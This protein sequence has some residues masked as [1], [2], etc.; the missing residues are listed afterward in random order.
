M[1]V[2]ALTQI[3]EVSVGGLPQAPVVA[4]AGSA[5]TPI[6][7]GPHH[8]RFGIRSWHHARHHGIARSAAANHPIT[9]QW[10]V[11]AHACRQAF[12]PQ[13]CC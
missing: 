1:Q 13:S 3:D 9:H 11:R 10:P 8:A 2:L 5:L 6:P 4:D 12:A 7:R